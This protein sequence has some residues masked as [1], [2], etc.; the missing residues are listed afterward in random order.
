MAPL[1]Y[2]A[3]RSIVPHVRYATK[4]RHV[5]FAP[6]CTKR[7][8]ATPDARNTAAPAPSW[9]VHRR[10]FPL[11]RA[12]VAPRNDDTFPL[13]RFAPNVGA[14]L[15]TPGIPPHL[16][17]HGR[18]IAAC[19]RPVYAV[20]E[21]HRRKKSGERLPSRQECVNLARLVSSRPKSGVPAGTHNETHT[22]LYY[23]LIT[24]STNH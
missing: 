24:Q 19:P 3:A 18:F 21:G 5:S 16:R 11:C 12:S 6:V 22:F 8:G 7:R 17:H 9:T 23:N 14:P 13:R 4:Q 10:T 15:V 1:R 20:N 2:I